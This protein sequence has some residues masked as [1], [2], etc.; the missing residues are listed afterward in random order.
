VLEACA[1]GVCSDNLCGFLFVIGGMR[2]AI[3]YVVHA[4]E[5]GSPPALTCL[6]SVP[7]LTV[8]YNNQFQVGQ[9]W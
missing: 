1:K 7:V 6:G 5:C 2:S 9:L 4:Y 3:E 8:D